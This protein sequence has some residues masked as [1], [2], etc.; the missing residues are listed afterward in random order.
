MTGIQN[1]EASF[2]IGNVVLDIHIPFSSSLKEKRMVL[3]S[4]KE[5][6]KAKFNVAVA[7]V[8]N[9]DLWQSAVLVITTVAPEKGQAE[10]VIDTVVNFV[11]SHFPE[12][13]INVYKEII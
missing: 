6:L 5:K 7:E 4:I 13:Y 9:Q 12:I 11:E 8:G 10:K 1:T 3:K 2:F